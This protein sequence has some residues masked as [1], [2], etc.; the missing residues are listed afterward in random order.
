[1]FSG[2]DAGV[3]EQF[4]VFVEDV[5]GQQVIRLV[6][7]L[8]SWV[9]PGDH[10]VVR[11]YAQKALVDLV[12]RVH[13]GERDI[14][15]AAFDDAGCDYLGLS[16]GLTLESVKAEGDD[17][18]FVGEGS[19]LNGLEIG[20]VD[21]ALVSRVVLHLVG[22]VVSLLDEHLLRADGA[23]VEDDGPKIQKAQTLKGLEVEVLGI[24][25]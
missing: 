9:L 8:A 14:V 13:I 7:E 22:G 5:A 11:G 20:E 3:F 17:G 6:N 15:R 23:L 21:Q 16:E 2:V 1:M 10:G 4:V 25:N 18:V 12:R 19:H 24:D